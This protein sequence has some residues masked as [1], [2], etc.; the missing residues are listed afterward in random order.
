MATKMNIVLLDGLDYTEQAELAHDYVRRT[1]L[2]F[3]CRPCTTA[4]GRT[5]A[6]EEPAS[7]VVAALVGENGEL[8]PLCETCYERLVGETWAAPSINGVGHAARG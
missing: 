6:A 5:K 8:T 4:L 3:R 1:G 7:E 2:A